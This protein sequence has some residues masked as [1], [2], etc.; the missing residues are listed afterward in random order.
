[1]TTTCPVCKKEISVTDEDTFCP[2]CRFPINIKKLIDFDDNDIKNFA[3][4]LIDVSA[5]FNTINIS[6]PRLK[7]AFDQLFSLNWLRPESALYSYLQIKALVKN[8]DYFKYPTL[9]LGC[10]DGIFTT[11]LFNGEFSS[12]ADYYGSIDLNQTDVFN[13]YTEFQKTILKRKPM[14]IGSGIDIKPTAIKKA[15]DLGVYDK[16]EKGDVRSLPFS[17]KSMNTIYTNMI[18]DIKNVDIPKVLDECHRVLDSGYLIFS[19]PTENFRNCLY[20]YPK[21]KELIKEGKISEAE[22]FV[23]YDR[24]RSAWEPR[25]QG[26]WEQKLKNSGFE[27]VKWEPFFYKEHLMYWDV[28]FRPFFPVLMKIRQDLKGKEY[29]VEFKKVILEIIKNYYYN[30]IKNVNSETET[31]VIVIAK[32]VKKS[33]KMKNERRK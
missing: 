24:K 19:T 1:M 31:F 8:W 23:A 32:K 17:D 9:D 7:N 27:L 14:P 16:L 5:P 28:G 26:Y 11:V 18:D 20:Y 6:D 15:Q 12:D 4:H 25:S 22:K 21:V 30:F 33:I 10:G 29:F 2:D 13:K 3:S